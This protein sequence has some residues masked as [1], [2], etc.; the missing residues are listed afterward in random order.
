MISAIK[1]MESNS[2]MN[3]LRLN[4]IADCVP[5]GLP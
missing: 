5:K 4:N 2:A 1:K 3:L